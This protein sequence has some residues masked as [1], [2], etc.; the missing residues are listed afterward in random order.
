MI[1]EYWSQR[2][3]H[4][5]HPDNKRKPGRPST[6]KLS[7]SN[8]KTKLESDDETANGS[9][10]K[11]RQS[12]TAV[13]KDRD[14]DDEARPKKKQ[15]TTEPAAVKPPRPSDPLTV[16][17]LDP[18]QLNRKLAEVADTGGADADAGE[19]ELGTMQPFMY[20]RT[21]DGMVQSIQ[22]VEQADDNTLRVYF[23]MCVQLLLRT[24]THAYYPPERITAK[25]AEWSRTRACARRSSRR[26]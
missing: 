18:E 8:S 1:D 25:S 7:K 12:T 9:A 13:K 24:L 22:T 17:T 19:P 23:V 26:R 16:R 5:D 11:R 4:K 21:W 6:G 10:K 2:K 15:K 3:T 20:M 14:S